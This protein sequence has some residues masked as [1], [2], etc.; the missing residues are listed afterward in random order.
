VYPISTNEPRYH[1]YSSN[2]RTPFKPIYFLP[3][4]AALL[5]TLIL[6]S[7]LSL[8]AKSSPQHAAKT[9]D[10]ITDVIGSNVAVSTLRVV[11]R[12][13]S[14]PNARGQVTVNFTN[15]QSGTLTSKE[16]KSVR[17]NRAYCAKFMTALRGT[18]G[19]LVGLTS[20]SP[21]GMC[22]K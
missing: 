11:T 15:G 4:I 3:G 13:V 20:P 14:A 7:I 18:S 9:V 5:L 10:S 21:S 6:L 22:N 8:T 12:S 1:A 19:A 16:A 2:L 17:P